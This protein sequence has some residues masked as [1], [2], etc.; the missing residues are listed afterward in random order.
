MPVSEFIKKGGRSD[1][2]VGRLREAREVAQG[3]L[4]FFPP[5]IRDLKKYQTKPVM[6][7]GLLTGVR[8]TKQKRPPFRQPLLHHSIDVMLFLTTMHSHFG[9]LATVAGFK[10]T[11]TLWILPVNLKGI[12]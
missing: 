10:S 9:A 2:S 1:S 5:S 7:R 3:R 12:S 4:C 8:F 6:N 11:V